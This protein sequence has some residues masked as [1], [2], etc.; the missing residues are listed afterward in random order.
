M[1]ML[2]AWTLEIDD[3]AV[4][5][6]EIQEQ[7]DMEKQLLSHSVGFITCSYDYVESGMVK[8][9]C[10]VLPFDVVG[11][12]TLT[13]SV[14]H[15]AGI[16]LL[17]L[18]VLTSDDCRFATALSRPLGGDT[19]AAV[20]AAFEHAAGPLRE[21]PGLVLAFLPMMTTVSGERMLQALDDA[22]SGAPVFGT[23]ACDSD[24]AHYSNSF[25]IHNGVC[26]R[27]QLSL[28]LING[29]VHPRFVVTATSEQN[30]HKQQAIIT[31]SEDSVLK[32]INGMSARDYLSSIGL[33][34]GSGIEAV[35][36]V[37]F[38]VNYNDGS[39]P[40]ARAIYSLNDDGTAVCGGVMPEGGTLSI[41]RLD[42]AD[43][44]L[45]AEQSLSTLLKNEGVSG[46]LMFPCLG[47]NMVLGV[48]P[49]VEIEKV[50]EILGDS[51]PWHLAYSG[52]EACPVY[53]N[54]GCAVNRFH[55]FTF[56][57]CAI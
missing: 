40:V 28:L 12:T 21:T 13:N 26:S 19:R 14:N 44:L 35:S 3:P 57:A 6:A 4:A 8:A 47:R 52:G 39:Q 11:C 7:L 48:T 49:L 29:N 36:S 38:V 15:E 42:V 53:G 25:T 31:S 37:P 10:D 41:G 32:E 18:S 23:I 34:Q 54:N 20:G 16:L 27:D 33:L 55:N 2:N 45:T 9:I 30:L 5:L 43:I 22:A 17:C 46:I 1:K 51:L 50:R 56:I 24:T